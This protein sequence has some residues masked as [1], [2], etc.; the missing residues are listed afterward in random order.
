MATAEVADT[1]EVEAS[2]A[3]Q[4]V[5]AFHTAHTAHIIPIPDRQY[6]L[7]IIT[8]TRDAGI[9]ITAERAVR[10][11]LRPEVQVV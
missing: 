3:R 4:A 9:T 1:M 10:Y 8:P 11:R 6:I 5:Q 2:T 7:T